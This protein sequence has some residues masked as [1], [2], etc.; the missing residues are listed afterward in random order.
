MYF[1]HFKKNQ[2]V[3]EFQIPHAHMSPEA[4]EGEKNKTHTHKL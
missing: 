3:P 1:L 2:N 4:R